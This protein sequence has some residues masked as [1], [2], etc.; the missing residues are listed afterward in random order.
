ML[1]EVVSVREQND[2]LFFDDRTNDDDT[3]PINVITYLEGIATVN[4]TMFVGNTPNVPLQLTT[5][6][7]PD[8]SITEANRATVD[9]Y[10]TID[11]TLEAY[12]ALKSLLVANYGG[13]GE[14][15]VA[16]SGD[17]L[18][19]RGFNVVLDPNAPQVRAFDGS[20]ITLRSSTFE[21]SIT[22]TGLVTLANGANV[23]GSVTDVN[24]TSVTIVFG[25]IIAGSRLLVQAQ[26]GG[27]ANDG[28]V[29]LNELI[30]DN[31]QSFVVTFEGNQP[32]FFRVRNASTTPQYRQFEGT[33]V[34]TINGFQTSI[35]Q[36]LD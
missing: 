14:T 27:P 30:T 31:P 21:G 33:G 36:E 13:E 11:S 4:P 10:N 23:S 29:I 1:V 34:I 22:T 35:I 3:I 32:I 2:I 20:T 9:G 6:L 17:T 28:D 16:R 5:A 7:L 18:D 19:A 24:G 26:S 25:D 15:I 12:D 8:F